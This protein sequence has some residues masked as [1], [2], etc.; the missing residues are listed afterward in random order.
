MQ[1]PLPASERGAHYPSQEDITRQ[2]LLDAAVFCA[3]R[4]GIQKTNMRLIAEASGIARQTVYNYF[5]N[6][7]EVLSAAFYREGVSL[8]EAAA[9]YVERFASPEEKLVEGFLFIYEHF[10]KNPILARVIDPG[11][12]FLATVGLSYYPFAQLGGLVFAEVFELQGFESD[13]AEDVSE[14]WIRNVLSFLTLPSPKRKTRT[15]LE[16]FV[17][18]RLLPGVGL[19]S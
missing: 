9:R 1:E 15:Q 8:G 7:N 18:Q 16:L 13:E 10:P 4:Y 6:K 19:R 3:D 14:L 17:R 11:D 5:K 2:K 12:N